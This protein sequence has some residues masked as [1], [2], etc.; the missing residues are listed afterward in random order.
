M[1]VD[2]SWLKLGIYTIGYSLTTILIVDA[3]SY[4]YYGEVLAILHKLPLI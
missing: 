3:C 4:K 1:F 2:V